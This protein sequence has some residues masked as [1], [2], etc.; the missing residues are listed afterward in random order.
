MIS[1]NNISKQ[2]GEQTLFKD[3][4]FSIPENAKIGVLGR[5][6]AGKSTFFK[7]MAQIESLDGGQIQIPKQKTLAWM[8]QDWSSSPSQTILSASLSVHERWQEAKAEVENLRTQLESDQSQGVLKKYED[9]ETNFETLGGQHVLV[10][11][12]EI[13]MGLGFS[14]EDLET[15]CIEFSGGWLIR[16]H[17]AGVLLQEAD[18]LLLDEPTNHLDMSSIL[19]F[20]QYLRSYSKAFM[21]ITHDRSLLERV[22]G[23]IIELLPPKMYYWPG[24]LSKYE[25]AKKQKFEQLESEIKSK[26]KKVAQM[27]DFVRRFRAKASKARQAQSKLKSTESMQKQIEELSEQIPPDS[28]RMARFSLKLSERLPK[29]V[30]NIEKAKFGYDVNDPLFFLD[31]CLI[32]RGKKIGLIGV[33]GVGKSTFLKT[34]S[35]ELP[36]LEGKVLV[37]PIVKLGFYAQH[38]MEDL[39]LEKKKK[40]YLFSQSSAVQVEEVYRV[41]GNL[42]LTQKDLEK[43]IHVLSG[44]EKARL[45]LSKILLEKPGLLLL[46][47][48][49]NHLD[50]E[51]CDALA[52]GLR[53]YEGTVLVVSHNRTFLDQTVKQI[54]EIKQNEC[55]IYH[56]NFTD[57]QQRIFEQENL[58][59]LNVSEKISAKKGQDKKEAKRQ[60][61]R[62]RQKQYQDRVNVRKK[63]QEVESELEEK[64]K[65]AL[66][67]DTFLI[68]PISMKS[69]DFG[70]K[71][72]RRQYLQMRIE[73]LETRW[74]ECSEKLESSDE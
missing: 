59:T 44:G 71:V 67:L 7:I 14:A 57:Y 25:E 11:A 23:Q 31:Q 42:G 37:S 5:N 8:R 69:K 27:E 34:C 66:E 72:Q 58:T 47:E 48:P 52:Q 50:L 74:L 65:E 62:E 40:N 2:F 30:I 13:L 46:D 53:E 51:S 1:V 22:S 45:S 24:S 70:E 32:E 63:L 56:G 17:L 43:D 20:E 21:L 16:A 33:N 60:E 4:S 18:L 3:V 55:H 15:P 9:A 64:K 61:A 73:N 49:T 39:P 19:W 36:P 6:G 38:R 26:Q 28:S 10:K 68:D 54:Y 41:A 29:V 35:G 12:K